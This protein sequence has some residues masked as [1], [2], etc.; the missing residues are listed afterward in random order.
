MKQLGII[1]LL[2]VVFSVSAMAQC[3]TWNDLSNKGEIEEAHVLYR[4]FFKQKNYAEAFP[5]WE[6][7]FN[8][9]PAA[10]GKR[11]LHFS[12]GVDMYLEQFKAETDAAKKE[13][14]KKTILDMYDAWVGCVE[15]GSIVLNNTDMKKYVGFIR[16]REAFN[17]YYTLNVPYS[18][19]IATLDKAIAVAGND[20]EYIILRPYANIVQYQFTNELMDKEKAREVYKTLNDIA[21]YNI[22]NNKQFGST[23]KA[24]KEAVNTVFST[25]ENNIFDC[26]YFKAKL[27]PDFKADPD[28]GAQTETILKTLLQRGCSQEDEDIMMM[29]EKYKVYADSVNE[30]RLKIFYEENPGPHAT[31]LYKDGKYDEAIARWE[32]AIKQ[33][34]EE[35]KENEYS[36]WIAYTRFHKKNTT[37]GVIGGAR[38]GTSAESVKGRAYILIGDY[39]AKVGRSCGDAWDQRLAI[40]GALEKYATAK[41]VD[42]SVADEANR[43][44][45][46]YASSKPERQEGFMRQVSEGQKVKSKC[47]GE[48]VTVRFVD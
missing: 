12:N 21:D 28:N 48:T 44:M 47:I 33:A 15:N 3:A 34:E 10:D 7:A 31:A 8:A 19:N 43:K 40:L 11:D 23:F 22:E 26:D 2:S 37:S 41:S 17:M 32:E 36:Y 5:Y 16:G 13:E 45:G 24:E 35:E 1:A 6:K 20:T 30:A 29:Q 9:A 4:D 42:P 14:L 46:I 27:M 18:D 39:Y 38:K 25:I